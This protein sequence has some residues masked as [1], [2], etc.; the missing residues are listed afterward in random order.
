MSPKNII[1]I[2][3]ALLLTAV[4]PRVAPAQTAPA[5][6]QSAAV[7]D[8]SVFTP[9][10]LGPSEF[11][12]ITVYP[13][14]ALAGA[15]LTDFVNEAAGREAAA[16][17]KEA[18]AP[19]I[20][21]A[22]S[23]KAATTTHTFTTP[24]GQ[25]RAAV[26]TALSLDG[27][28]AR[29]IE[30]VLSNLAV[31]RR[32]QPQQMAVIAGVLRQEKTTMP[33]RGTTPGMTPGGQVVPGIYAGNAVYSDT[34]K[35][36]RQRRLYLFPSGEFQMCDAAG[37]EVEY[38]ADTCRYDPV[39]GKMD[40]GTMS[41]SLYNS[42]LGPDDAYCLY[43]RD[44]DGKPCIRARDNR[45]FEYLVT[46]LRYVGPPDRPPPRQ[47][48]EAKAAAE[49]EA[50][51]YK[52][53]TPPGKGV[54]AAQ[55]A[56][57]FHDYKFRYNLAA[58]DESYL[59]LKDGTV[60][61]GLPVPPDELD[62]P[63]SRRREPEKWGHWRRQ[64]AKILVSWPDQPNHFTALEGEMASPATAGE[65][66][67]GR[68]GTGETSG[69]MVTG[70]SYRLWGVTF[71]PEGRF[72]KDSSGGAS[73]GSLGATTNGFSADTVYDDQGSATIISAP[74]VG[75]GVTRK[76]P[77]G[78]RGGTYSVS[79]YTLTLHYDDGRVARL[80]FFSASPKHDQIY[81]DGATLGLDAGK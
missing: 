77:R 55:I 41:L 47:Q 2:A 57:I 14:A 37:K 46:T 50:A 56:G 15:S 25:T 30:I 10:D 7:G 42:S 80:P 45:G 62:M 51:R 21:K 59:L 38:G 54:Q 4:A 52:F 33:R 73:G 61:D 78:H 13:P 71:T 64:G 39:T 27:E 66:M 79:G 43:G 72:L 18:A 81:F 60:H 40:I 19:I 48:K 44:L 32:Y 35:I 23:A 76:K 26:F 36:A 1:L 58:T 49:A 75:G 16:L 29:V 17:G 31:L 68:F 3:S 6:W 9:P 63:V 20:A 65:R 8:R 24:Q 5:G 74:A 12:Q 22:N 53:V 34:G 11:Y 28:N 70:G 69:S 67:S